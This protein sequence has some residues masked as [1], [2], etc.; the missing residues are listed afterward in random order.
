MVTLR[1]LSLLTVF[2][3]TVFLMTLVS[4]A[5]NVSVSKSSFNETI[6]NNFNITLDAGGATNITNVNITLPAGLVFD[7]SSNSTYPV[8][9]SL[10]S[11][12]STVLS[13]VHHAPYIMNGTDVK[14][15]N[16]TAVAST[17]G[18]Y[19]INVS[20]LNNSQIYITNLT[21]EINDTSSPNNISFDGAT[22]AGAINQ[23]QN[24]IYVNVTAIDSEGGY[25]GVLANT[26]FQLSH[27]NGTVLN[28][29]L[30]TSNLEAIN[31]TSLSDGVYYINA[32]ANDT[33][34]HINATGTGIRVITVD[35]TA[36]H[37]VSF[38]GATHSGATNQSQNW[39]FINVSVNDSSGVFAGS[40][41]NITYQ[42]MYS[43]GTVFNR[44]IA[45]GNGYN[46]PDAINFTGLADGIYYIN[47]T[48]NDT[49]G[50]INATGTG[51]R[52]ITIDASAPFNVSFDGATTGENTN[53]SQTWIGVNITADDTDSSY[54]GILA[55]ITYSLYYSN[56]SLF[57]RTIGSTNSDFINFTNLSD[58]VYHLNATANDTLGNTNSTGTGTRII[59]LDTTAPTISSFSC[60]PDSVTKE[61]TVTCS[62]SRSDA[63][64]GVKTATFTA[65]PSTALTGAH[66][67]TCTVTD[68]AGNSVSASADFT[69]SGGSSS[70]TG[71]GGGSS[72]S[73]S[74]SWA[75]T[76]K[77]TEDEVNEG[78][79]KSLAKNYRVEV[80]AA[81]GTHHIGLTDVT[82]SQATIE[83]SS[84]PQKAT[85]SVN[86]V[87]K[88][89]L[90]ADNIYDISVML[91]KI[92][93]KTASL[94]ITG[95]SE[96]YTSTESSDKSET[97]AEDK[98]T[99]QIT[100][101]PT[102]SNKKIYILSIIIILIIVAVVAYIYV[103]KKRK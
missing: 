60:S 45:N 98:V 69:V 97:G 16:F 62:C 42:L 43:N 52:A 24:W 27:S 58:G 91:N 76:Y 25:A 29:T 53:L 82:D 47:A 79:T 63:T 92:E 37:N 31:F 6:T 86:E 68:W 41:A 18:I 55:N 96:A 33:F 50:N 46:N 2:L 35:T 57:N 78:Y 56:G 80:I 11:N 84:T 21:I 64:S 74:S 71:G 88:F 59:T 19:L 34:G 49:A 20:V 65:S 28:R 103:S 100:P 13:W 102:T 48:A 30:V 83:V 36:P 94:T 90:N 54:S 26:T 4:S 95:I 99:D 85:L 14:N 17:P 61:E 89:D 51:T 73:S 23:S 7:L 3:S 72:S 87:K 15:F 75:A 70:I 67:E 39:I 32:T 40:L 93:F 5:T 44:T 38:D 81:G 10:F 9:T 77:V 66:T 12:T 1:G 22:H 101:E 8:N